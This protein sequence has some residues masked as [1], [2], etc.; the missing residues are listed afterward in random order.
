M[1]ERSPDRRPVLRIV[2]S[3]K[4]LSQRF[5]DGEL[6]HDPQ[7]RETFI[8]NHRVDQHRANLG[9]LRPPTRQERERF[10]RYTDPA[11]P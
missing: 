11:R 8:Y 10:A 9:R 4:S 6:V 3:K 1:Y 7:H 2:K 5:K